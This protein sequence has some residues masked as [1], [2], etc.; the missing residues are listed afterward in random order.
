M[1]IR[2]LQTTPSHAPDHPFQPGQVITV[3]SL[4]KESRQWLKDGL[5]TIVPEEPEAAVE[6]SGERAVLPRA[7]ERHVR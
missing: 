1:Q 2:F 7:R 6:P 4:T 5:A 3:T